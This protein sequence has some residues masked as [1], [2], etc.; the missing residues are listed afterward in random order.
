MGGL[1]Y[2]DI[3]DIPDRD[4]FMESTCVV[5]PGVLVCSGSRVG[6]VVRSELM[7]L[8]EGMITYLIFANPVDE[9]CPHCLAID[10]MLT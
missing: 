8:G 1:P 2:L 10:V 6:V 5:D 3:L 4:V 9:I 7:D